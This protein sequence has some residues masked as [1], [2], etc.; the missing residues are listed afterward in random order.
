MEGTDLDAF[1][2]LLEGEGHTTSDNERVD[3]DRNTF[4]SGKSDRW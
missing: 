1:K 4:V 3:L 2:G